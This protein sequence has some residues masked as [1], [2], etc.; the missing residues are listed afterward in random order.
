MVVVAFKSK[1]LP[2]ACV[3]EATLYPTRLDSFH[4]NL[5][6]PIYL[7]HQSI[8]KTVALSGFVDNVLSF[9]LTA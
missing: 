2:L 6:H 8:H 5:E 4:L 7:V 1:V 3:E 9:N